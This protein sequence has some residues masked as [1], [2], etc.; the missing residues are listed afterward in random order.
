MKLSNGLRMMR[1]KLIQLASVIIGKIPQTI[2]ALLPYVFLWN[3]SCSALALGF[4][5]EKQMPLSFILI[6]LIQFWQLLWQLY[7]FC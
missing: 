1:G 7:L 6:K 2:A 5:R 3:L 4:A